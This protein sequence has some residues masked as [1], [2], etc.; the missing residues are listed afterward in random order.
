LKGEQRV[1]ATLGRRQKAIIA[2]LSYFSHGDP[3]TIAGWVYMPIVAVGLTRSQ[4]LTIRESLRKL[5]EKGMV[6]QCPHL[7][8]KGETCWTLAIPKG[9][10]RQR[11]KP[12]V[13]L[14]LVNRS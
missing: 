2:Y 12:M 3:I 11:K 6:K 14:A 7:T 10:R 9:V 8:E 1:K 4:V 5:V 13:K